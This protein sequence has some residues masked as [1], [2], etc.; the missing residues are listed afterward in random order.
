[1]TTSTSGMTTPEIHE[2]TGPPPLKHNDASVGNGILRVSDTCWESYTNTIIN[3]AQYA[4]SR[5]SQ[6]V[7]NLKMKIFQLEEQVKENNAL[8]NDLKKNII[9]YQSQF[10]QLHKSKKQQKTN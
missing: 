8:I 10:D 6:E 5:K 2:I 9:D 4:I 7:A 3:G 1:M